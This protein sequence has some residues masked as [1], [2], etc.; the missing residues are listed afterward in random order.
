MKILEVNCNDLPGHVFNGYDLHNELNRLGYD[1]KQMVRKKY[2]NC[3]TVKSFLEDDIFLSQLIEWEKEHSVSNVLVPYGYELEQSEEFRNA[4]IVHYHILHNYTISL[5]D[6]PN[7][8][9]QKCSIWTIHDPW[10][11]TG[12]CIHPLECKKWDMGCGGCVTCN[13]ETF[14]MEQ[15]NTAFM[16][17]LKKQI[18]SKLNPDIIVA[19]EFMKKYIE[20]SPLTNHFNKIH[21]IPFGV[22][23]EKYDINLKAEKKIKLGFSLEDRVIGFRADD[24]YIKGTYY[25]FE[26]LKKLKV[27]SNITLISFGNGSVPKEIQKKYKIIELGWVNDEDKIIEFLEGIDIFLMP[28]LAEGFGV[29]AIEAMAAGCAVICFQTTTVEEITDAPRCGIAVEYKSSEA[30]A[31]AIQELLNNYPEIK[32][33]GKLGNELV[34]K[35]YQFKD[36]VDK[37]IALYE[38]IYSS[39]YCERE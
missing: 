31:E 21:I 7:L 13:N 29:M 27:D 36:Y 5:L 1:A 28:S 8:M 26:A 35:K 9:N 38:K 19:S 23:L 12:N 24:F 4:E 39:Y 11:L 18:L 30:L 10:I 2:S 3:N 15:D 20:K 6:Y 25:L 14:I 16:W 17:N 22:R 32:R 33:R 34:R 37:H